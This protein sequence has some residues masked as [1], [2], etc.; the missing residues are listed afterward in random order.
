MS[1]DFGNRDLIVYDMPM[2]NTSGHKTLWVIVTIIVLAG[3]LYAWIAYPSTPAEAAIIA[4]SPKGG[5]IW[6]TGSTHIISWTTQGVPSTDKISLTIR[7]IP[8]PRLQTEGQEFDPIIA[9]NLPNSGS[10]DWTIADM[11]PPGTYVLGLTAYESIPVTNPISAESASFEIVPP[12][13]QALYPL[14]SAASWN[15]PHLVSLELPE[16]NLYGTGVEA[17]V[18]TSTMNPG[19]AFSPFDTYYASKLKALGWKV[20]NGLA[21]GGPARGQTVYRKDNGFIAVNFWTDFHTISSTSPMQCPCDV[22]LK[23]FS[24]N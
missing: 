5:E 3:G 17:V 24:T 20:D 16:E 12:L 13:S 23:L 10:Y 21:A 19:A 18:A 14:Y 22:T 8:P 2:E 9:I 11:Y 15:E 1:H 4:A 7:R 6:Q